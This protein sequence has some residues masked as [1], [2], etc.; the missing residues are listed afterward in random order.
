MVHV[1]NNLDKQGKDHDP[2]GTFIR[3]WVPEIKD[4]P[5]NFIHEPWLMEKFNSRY[6]SNSKYIK[7]IIN[8][9][10]TSKI[11]RKKI[12]EISQRDG[13]WDISKEIYLKHGSRKKPSI[14]KKK[15]IKKRESKPKNEYQ[16]ELNLE[17]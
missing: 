14:K 8:L 4:L 9:L 16:Y 17:L 10:Q 3:K 12:Q 6:Y 1:L 11:A 5:D 13:Y 15:V 7:P 2:E